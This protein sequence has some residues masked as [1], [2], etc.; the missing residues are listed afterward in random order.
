MSMPKLSTLTCVL[1]AAALASA[2]GADSLT[3][4]R[5]SAPTVHGARVVVGTTVSFRFSAHE[6][7]VAAARLRFRCAFDT[8][9]LHGCAQTY[10]ARLAVGAHVLRVRAVDPGGQQSATT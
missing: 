1:L 2:A 7:G 9:R 3:A 5:P 4:A 8:T 10:R 6:A